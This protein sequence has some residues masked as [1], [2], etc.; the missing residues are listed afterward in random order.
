MIESSK[1]KKR[2]V[3]A[4]SGGVDSSVAAALLVRQGYEVIGVTMN[5]WRAET[6]VSGT[7][8]CSLE[9]AEDAYRVAR[10]LGF[11]HYHLDFRKE[12]EEYVVR[13][14]VS[15][16]ADGRT[17]NPCIRCN[18]YLKFDFFRERA[19]AVFRADMVATG[20]YARISRNE[21]TGRWLL[22]RGVDSSRDQAYALYALSQD[23][24]AGT[25]FPLGGM[26]K[27]E[28]R[29]LALELK[30]PVA[31]KPDSQE[32][33]FVP[34]NDYR[35]FI[36]DYAPE[37]YKS[38]DIVDAKGNVV[39]KHDGIAFYTIGQ[40]KGIGAHGP[41][42]SYVI[43]INPERNEIVIGAEAD[44]YAR[45]AIAEDVNLINRERI[46][47]EIRVEAQIRYN[48]NA[49]RGIARMEGEHLRVDFDVPQR[50][51][52]PGQ[53][54]VA[55]EGETVLGGGTIMRSELGVPTILEAM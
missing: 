14:F 47:S 34:D 2:V 21:Q 23:Q 31:D 55:Y 30:L 4:M 12:F 20:H 48:T 38:G 6:P 1:D 15:E 29:N 42:P 43:R 40:R 39:G 18:Q 46:E 16:Y 41:V 9:T 11:E 49:S 32:I 45:T 37:V 50:A 24:L 33:C 53:A 44:L 26:S 52:T 35:G 36:R 19:K 54:L 51:I 7:H 17:P 5:L 25:L 8:C 22:L 13:R 3:V 10:I 28:V 27:V